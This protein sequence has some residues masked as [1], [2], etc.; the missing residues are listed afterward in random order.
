MTNTN[1]VQIDGQKYDAI[2]G[3]P[4]N[5]H[6]PMSIEVNTT[7]LSQEPHHTPAKNLHVNP[8]RS[9]TLNRKATKRPIS[10]KLTIHKH[11]PSIHA[12]ATTVH[13][14]VRKFTPH[15]NT[16]VEQTKVMDI[17]PVTHPHVTKAHA[18]SAAKAHTMAQHAQSAHEIKEEAVKQAVASTSKSANWQK[19]LR[20]RL[21]PK[22]RTVAVLSSVFALVI[23]GGYFTYLN[24]PSLSVRVAAAQAG[25]NA[26]YP[27]YHPDGY[28]LNGPV[29]F[30]DGRVSINFKA[31]AGEQKFSISQSQSGWSN[32]AVLDNYVT[33]KA[34]SNYIP[35]TERGLTIYTY[36]NSAAWVNGGILYTLEG[37]APLSSEQ[38]RRIATSLL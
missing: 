3:M 18:I 12:T 22:Q 31:N 9:M 33:P 23:L 29:S 37:N 35:Y 20:D 8:Q 1:F 5:K 13:S 14:D 11:Q 10:Q 34:G 26:S 4:V 27:N 19:P 36:N 21:Q 6:V 17:G 16:V 38:V 30:S 32:E 25:I 28:A 15:T 24:M 7:K 2:T